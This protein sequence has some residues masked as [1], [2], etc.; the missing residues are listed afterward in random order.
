MSEQPDYT[1]AGEV[2]RKSMQEALAH[3]DQLNAEVLKAKEK[4]IDQEIAAKDEL[5]RI[6][7]DAEKLSQEFISQH[8]KDYDRRVRNDT[9]MEVVEKLLAAGL[10]SPEVKRWLEVS[11]EMIAHAFIYLKFELLGDRMANVY[12][13]N[14]GKAGDVYFNWDGI[15]LKFPFEFGGGNVL[16]IIDVPSPE[17]WVAKTGLPVDQRNQVLDFI[18]QRVIRD[19][20]PN[21]LYEITDDYI[22]ILSGPRNN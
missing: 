6:Q 8:Q 19:Q 5:L 17:H 14:K 21:H 12:Y 7:R 2:F 18:A 15:V 3:L 13:D 20:A 16:A 9:L 1:E 4:A 11:D 10:P 22:N